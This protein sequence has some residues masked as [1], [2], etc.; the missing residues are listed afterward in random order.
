MNRSNNELFLKLIKFAKESTD[1]QEKQTSQ[2]GIIVVKM[3]KNNKRLLLNVKIKKNSN[4]PKGKFIKN[5][6]LLNSYKNVINNDNL[7]KIIIDNIQ[8]PQDFVD[9]KNWE[10]IP[11]KIKGVYYSK[12]PG[13]KYPVVCIIPVN[14][15]GQENQNKKSQLFINNIEELSI[16]KSLLNN[17]K[18]ESLLAIIE[19]INREWIMYFDLYGING[20]EKFFAKY[21]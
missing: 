3:P 10:K 11:S 14:D 18:L 16:Y 21:N 5:R 7:K 15:N 4:S 20:P 8:K 17:L 19:D 1:W 13:K 2:V 12:I 9:I 6:E